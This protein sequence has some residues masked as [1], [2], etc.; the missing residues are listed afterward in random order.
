MGATMRSLGLVV[1][2][3]VAASCSKAAPPVSAPADAPRPPPPIIDAEPAPAPA[4]DARSDSMPTSMNPDPAQPTFSRGAPIA[5]SEALVTWLDAQTAA[6][7]LPF[8]LVLSKAGGVAT[9]TIG[10]GGEAEPIEVK[11]SDLQMGVSL[12]DRL[13]KVCKPG[14]TCQ[15]WLVGTWGR[16][17]RLFNVKKLD[18]AIADPSTATHAEVE[19]E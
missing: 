17:Q 7:R 11:L 19:A 10:V 1:P 4:V 14:E 18:G 15:V 5:P 13:R 3:L 2:A 12:K 6:V 9:A 16:G 8:T